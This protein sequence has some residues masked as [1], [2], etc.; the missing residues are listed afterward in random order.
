MVFLIC[1]PINLLLIFALFI[2]SLNLLALANCGN[3]CWNFA[4]LMT[5]FIILFKYYFKFDFFF[6]FDLQLL[7]FKLV[8]SNCTI[9]HGKCC[10]NW[11]TS[12]VYVYTIIFLLFLVEIKKKKYFKYVATT[13]SGFVRI[14][15]YLLGLV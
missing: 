6:S 1:Q 8:V 7:V 4:F 3:W 10:P 2:L 12:R 11:N 9:I 15:F 14:A 5:L 13:V